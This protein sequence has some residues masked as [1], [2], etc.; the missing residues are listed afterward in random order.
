VDLLL[1][2]GRKS[3]A[4][5]LHLAEGRLIEAI[6]AF[7]TDDQNKH[8]S[9]VRAKDCI[10]QAFWRLLPFGTLP[11]DHEEVSKLSERSKLLDKESLS[12]DDHDEVGFSMLSP[13]FH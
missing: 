3:D 10:L 7:L 9:H 13:F 1:V 5:E 8:S 11:L 4:A 6:D 2:H 12:C